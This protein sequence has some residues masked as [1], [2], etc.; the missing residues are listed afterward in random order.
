MLL[1][2]QFVHS[3][4]VFGVSITKDRAV[5]SAASKILC[6]TNWDVVLED[7]SARNGRAHLLGCKCSW[8]RFLLSSVCFGTLVVLTGLMASTS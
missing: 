6:D 2:E 5:R 4:L 3:S 7:L 1:G 8:L